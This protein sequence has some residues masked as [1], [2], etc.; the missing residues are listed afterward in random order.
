MITN[1]K[2]KDRIRLVLIVVTFVIATVLFSDWD[3]FK[4]GLFAFH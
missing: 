4:A 1:L 2:N 3:H